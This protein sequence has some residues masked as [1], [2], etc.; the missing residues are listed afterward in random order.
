MHFTLQYE[1]DKCNNFEAGARLSIRWTEI[2]SLVVLESELVLESRLKTVFSWTRSICA[3]CFYWLHQLWWVLWSLDDESAKTLVHAFVTAQVDWCS[4][5]LAGASR[6]V[7]DRLQRVFNA[8]LHASSVE[9]WNVQVQLWTV[10]A[11]TYWL[12]LARCGRWSLVQAR[13]S[14][15]CTTKCQ[16]TWR[17]AVSLSRISLVVRDSTQH[18]V[19]SWMYRAINEQHSAVGHLCRW[20]NRLAFA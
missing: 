19:A 11:A 7:T 15:V 14:G 8:V 13:S 16:S 20:T 4:M 3:A 9:R 12:A 5:V 18:T 2:A 10:T 17:T 1:M 6:S